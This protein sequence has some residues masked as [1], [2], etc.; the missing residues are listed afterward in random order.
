MLPAPIYQSVCYY[1]Q[2]QRGQEPAQ[3]ECLI[4]EGI[5]QKQDYKSIAKLIS[6]QENTVRNIASI[7][8]QDLST[9]IGQKITKSNFAA[10]FKQIALDRQAAIDWEDAPT[11]IQPFCG[12]TTEIKQL[13][14]W[15]LVDRCKIVTIL[16]IGGI[17]K[18][19][20]AAKLGQQLQD[21]FNFI[22]WRSLREAP[23]LNQL[24]GDI[25]P[26]LARH[27]I[28]ELPKTSPKRISALLNC[29]KEQR[30]LLILDNVEAIMTAG[31]FVGNYREG[32]SNYGEL[33]HRL[34][35]TTHQSCTLLTSREAP[36]EII[37]LA[38]AKLPIR[39]LS[40]S[41]LNGDGA[42]LL[43][44]MD[45]QGDRQILQAISDRCHGNPLYLRII[46]SIILKNFD[47][48]PESFLISD[49]YNY[50]KIST[51]ITE[52]LAR[53]TVTEKLVVYHLSLRREP[54]SMTALGEHFE[55]MSLQGNLVS[56]IDSLIRRSIVQTVGGSNL[57][58][59]EV[60]GYTLQ[61][62]ILEL[63]TD[64]LR[65][66]LDLELQTPGNLF[67]FNHLALHPTTSPEY[68]RQ[69][70]QRLFLNPLSRL[71]HRRHGVET[72]SFI[73]F[74]I[75]SVTD[76]TGYAVGNLI[77]LAI[78][79]K[80]NF[81]N[82][83][84]SNLHIAEVDFQEVQLA[85]VNFENSVFDRCQFPQGMGTIFELKFSPNGQLL[86]A[87]GTDGRVHVWEV[88]TGRKK[89][90][91]AGHTGWIRTLC[92][93]DDGK[94][95]ATGSGDHTVRV[96]DTI[97]GECLHILTGHQDI[98]WLL[99]FAPNSSIVASIDR[100]R[101]I[102]VW[103]LKRQQPVF[104][105]K[106]S[107]L[108]I[109]NGTIDL[110]KGRLVT[111]SPEGIAVRSLWQ[112]GKRMLAIPDQKAVK[113]IIFSPDKKHLWGLT[114]D[115]EVYCWNIE[116]GELVGELIGH[117][118]RVF[119][120]V[121]TSDYQRIV[122]TSKEC[123]RV[124]NAR[125]M[126]CLQ[127]IY[128]QQS[129]L[130]VDLHPSGE[131]MAIASGNGV[132]Q[133][134][135]IDRGECLLNFSGRT[136]RFLTAIFDRQ[137]QQV[138]AGRDDGLILSWSLTGQT[139]TPGHEYVGHND[140]VRSIAISPD[141]TKLVSGSHDTTVRLWNLATGECLKVMTGHNYWVSHVM[142]LDD[143][144]TISC[145]EDG[146]ICHW[147]F[148]TNKVNILPT[149]SQY[150]LMGVG[151]SVDG[152]IAI[153]GYNNNMMDLWNFATKTMQTLTTQGNRIR[154]ISFSQNLRHLVTLSD[155]GLLSLCDYQQ[156]TRIKTWLVG[157]RDWIALRFLPQDQCKVAIAGRAGIEIW[158]LTIGEC[159]CKLMEHTA[160]VCS[161]DFTP[162]GQYLLS[163]SEDGTVKLWDIAQRKV[164]QTITDV[165][166][167]HHPS[168]L[169]LGTYK[170]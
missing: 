11:D 56:T 66:E 151:A 3:V 132:V 39:T 88:A 135:E 46:A 54:I 143:H 2:Q 84:L 121:F 83:D 34:G 137:A 47:G 76:L 31:E 8:L 6:Y 72:I 79:L 71:L 164:I 43:D 108:T 131:K 61:N 32:Y 142:F 105:V 78:E 110:S 134:W 49:R 91:L 155:D 33:F 44:R 115:K 40:L 81:T 29:L 55:L 166:N 23:P 119:D 98:V 18:T 57:D 138:F 16:G 73:Q 150:W 59:Q 90:L 53:L 27:T 68:I 9:A 92:F 99:Y 102:N 106:I 36:N 100:L 25:I 12:R 7:L 20:L 51:I 129:T 141:N 58:R 42:T 170:P 62:V 139:T 127:S 149:N 113:K 94:Y 109:W 75:R 146:K 87:G 161:I 153:A 167:I 15:I 107:D 13:T 5:W 89:F 123:I 122:T 97:S 21:G 165:K 52:Q 14:E 144:Q 10:I 50:S 95:L 63:A 48:D 120:I 96:W 22:I 128:P 4:I 147:N 74:T 45:V 30:C 118:S 111:A 125:T 116:T 17:G 85:E 82:W 158:D 41:G 136:M 35:T 157:G 38:G 169:E 145:G 64:R 156:L 168:R 37:E 1:L 77:N 152:Q 148:V 26:F 28:S 160:P 19:S 70:Q 69:I 140:I 112:R 67:F 117:N 24:L 133:L 60:K 162:D 80:A 126:T 104:S 93:S 163:S 86:A 159:T 154:F 103:W 114:F 124:W 101:V 130:S 65:A